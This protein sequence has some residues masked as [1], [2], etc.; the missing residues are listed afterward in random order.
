MLRP[1][2]CVQ[3]RNTNPSVLPTSSKY[4]WGFTRTSAPVGQ[5]SSHEYAGRFAPSGF[6]EVFSQRLHLMAIM[7]SPS[8]TGAG[9]GVL[10]RKTFLIRVSGAV[11]AGGG[12]SRGIIEMALYGHCVAQSKQPMQ[13][14]GL[15]S[16]SPVRSGKIAP[17][18]EPVRHSGSL[19]CMQTD[20]DNT[21]C[22]WALPG[23]MGRS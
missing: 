19:Q 13:V 12:R 2:A 5:F 23:L 15:I 6:R 11:R 20:G 16:T 18:G 14:A 7:S 4:S 21:C 3:S 10:N 9:A 1:I 17:V 22:V 8:P